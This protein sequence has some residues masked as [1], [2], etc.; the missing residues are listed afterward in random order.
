MNSENNLVASVNQILFSLPMIIL[1]CLIYVATF[2]YAGWLWTRWPAVKPTFLTLNSDLIGTIS[3]SVSYFIFT[4]K[5]LSHD[6]KVQ[7]KGIFKYLLFLVGNTILSLIMGKITFYLAVLAM[8]VI[9]LLIDSIPFYI[10]YFQ[11]IIGG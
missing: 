2:I 7:D 11:Q 10:K 5:I 6:F 1:A 8:F 4:G 3:F 9:L